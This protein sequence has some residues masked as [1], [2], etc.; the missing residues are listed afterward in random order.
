MSDYLE[1]KSLDHNLGTA[2]FTKPSA[3]YVGLYTGDPLDNGT[4]PEVPA[5]YGHSRQVCTFN[6]A[7]GGQAAN[8][9]IMYFGPATT[10]WG[11]ITHFAVWDAPTG[12]NMLYRGSV[13]QPKTIALGDM[14]TYLPGDLV[15]KHD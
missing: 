7:S 12:G 5:A 2:T 11:S 1:N 6:P 13:D 10:A 4:G 3:T 15:I 9:V 14:A 8:N